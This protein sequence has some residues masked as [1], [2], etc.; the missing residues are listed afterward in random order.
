MRCN[1]VGIA[2]RNDDTNVFGRRISCNGSHIQTSFIAGAMALLQWWR[3]AIGAINFTVGTLAPSWSSKVVAQSTIV[4]R[5]LL[6]PCMAYA[7]LRHFVA[8]GS[9]LSCT[10]Y[11]ACPCGKRLIVAPS[12]AAILGK[13]FIVAFFGKRLVVALLD[14]CGLLGVFA[15]LTLGSV[16]AVFGVLNVLVFGDV[17]AFGNIHAIFGVLVILDLSIL[18]PLVA[19][20]RDM[21]VVASCTQQHESLI[22]AWELFGSSLAFFIT[23]A[24]PCNTTYKVK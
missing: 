4:A 6:L 11:M 5:G 10:T 15:I 7:A 22:V 24:T 12:P 16:H 20:W 2:S 1:P 17:H 18:A 3:I 9:L 14:G 19:A 13:G 23:V 8:R 21:A